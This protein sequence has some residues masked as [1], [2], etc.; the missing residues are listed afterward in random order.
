MPS[1]S[2]PFSRLLI[3]RT[4]ASA[5][6]CEC[7]HAVP[8]ALGPPGS[9]LPVL[10]LGHT[11]TPSTRLFAF[12]YVYEL[13][14]GTLILGLPL[15]FCLLSTVLGWRVSVQ[16]AIRFICWSAQL[17]HELT[18]TY[19]CRLCGLFAFALKQ[20]TD[21]TALVLTVLLT[22]LRPLSCRSTAAVSFL[23]TGSFG[24]T[25]LALLVGLRYPFSL[26][27]PPPASH[28]SRAN[29]RLHIAVRGCH[30]S[31]LQTSHSCL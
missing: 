14:L 21:F 31:P 6:F 20:C 29:T 1:A 7:S 8:S 9:S 5:V 30:T 12:W 3:V 17:V 4:L 25:S 18:D 13:S 15:C 22:L 11:R 27:R 28:D 26:N 19:R 16:V 24:F 10:S 2:T 23:L